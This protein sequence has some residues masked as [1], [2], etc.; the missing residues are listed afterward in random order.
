[1]KTLLT[2]FLLL[3]SVLIFG[4]DYSLSFNGT[5][6]YIECS[7]QAH[8]R[9][10]TAATVEAWI[11]ISSTANSGVIAGKL[12]H[13]GS[14][15]GY[16]LFANS[17]GVFAGAAPGQVSFTV[18][19]N[20][21][22]MRSVLSSTILSTG[23]WYHVAGTFDGQILKIYI[24]GVLD[25]TTDIGS[26]Y[27]IIPPTE[28]PFSIGKFS[29]EFARYFNGLIDEVN[30]WNIAR[31]GEQISATYN[32]Y[33]VG[34]E[35]GL[36]YYS[37][38]NEGS[39]STV[40][41]AQTNYAPPSTGTIYNATWV[42]G[43]SPLPVELTFF[44]ANVSEGNIVLNWQTATEVN[45][46][47][48]EVE[49]SSQSAAGSWQNIGFVEGSGNSNSTKEYSFID[50][51]VANG[52]YSYRLKQIDTDGSYSYSN[53]IT[54]ETR[55]GE[56]LPTEFELSQN[57]P[58]PFNPTTTIKYTIPA[59]VKAQ[60]MA[61]LRVYDIL[62]NQVATLVNGQKEP[63]YYEVKFEAS[64]FPS[65]VY[66]YVLRAGEEFHAVKKMLFIK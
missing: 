39:G 63:G 11:K 27:V 65:G 52:D 28:Y 34:N 40:A 57:Y 48:F 44:T 21:N 10:T 15:W 47:G 7:D 20:W 46:Y 35:A 9:L 13:S 51:D 43:D 31:T 2:F 1:M 22:S 58:N 49:R 29:A 16:G 55:R 38:M 56:S 54:V 3:N 30:V 26:S 59:G 4:Q 33:L 19:R 14:Q 32:T 60:C 50:K 64:H 36:V 62:G 23:T 45:N 53:E 41:D 25:N 24:N 5:N 37:K 42:S 17:D 66:F 6:A 61:S 18:G 12:Y 8:L